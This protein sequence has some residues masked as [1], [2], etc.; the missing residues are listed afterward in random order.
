MS[1][2]ETRQSGSYEITNVRPSGHRNEYVVTITRNGRPVGD[3]KVRAPVDAPAYFND[4]KDE[5]RLQKVG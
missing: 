2:K 5:H 3:V 4:A 1:G